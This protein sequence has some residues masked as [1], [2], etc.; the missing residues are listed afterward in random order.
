[1]IFYFSLFYRPYSLISAVFA[2]CCGYALIGNHN[3]FAL[4]LLPYE[5]YQ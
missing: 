4:Y 2:F 5:T 3:L 1:M